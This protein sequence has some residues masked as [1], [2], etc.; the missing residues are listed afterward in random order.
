MKAKVSINKN[1]SKGIEQGLKD[2]IL[3]VATDIHRRAIILAPV[4]TRALVKSGRIEGV[5]DGYRIKFGNSAVPYARLRH[6]ENKKNPST[7]KYLAKAGE[8]VARA[9]KSKYFRG[10]V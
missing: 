7:R 9:D 6:E 1:W 5:Q 8:S 10:K 2:G 3:E 4:D